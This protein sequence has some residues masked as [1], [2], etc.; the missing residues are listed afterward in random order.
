MCRWVGWGGV[1]F[2]GFGGRVRW[3]SDRYID[4]ARDKCGGGRDTGR[5]NCDID[6]SSIK[7]IGARFGIDAGWGGPR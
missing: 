7:Y 4:F 2:W 6:A 1:Y 5:N 3:I